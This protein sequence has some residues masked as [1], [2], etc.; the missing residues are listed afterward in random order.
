MGISTHLQTFVGSTHLPVKQFVGDDGDN[1]AS[2]RVNVEHVGGR[3]VRRL[4]DDVV[5]QRGVVRAGVVRVQRR[6]GHHRGTW[7]THRQTGG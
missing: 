1:V 7:S 6:H 2:F 5:A 3:L 4:P